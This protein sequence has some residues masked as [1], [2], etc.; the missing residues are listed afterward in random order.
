MTKMATDWETK[1]WG[2]TRCVRRL[3]NFS[4]YELEVEKGGFCSIH[5]HLNRSNEFLVLSGVVQVVWCFAWQ[6]HSR[7]LAV[8]SPS[9]TIRAGIPHQFQVMESGVMIEDYK[10]DLINARAEFSDGDIVRLTEGGRADTL[11]VAGDLIV[12][13]G[14]FGFPVYWNR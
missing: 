5:Y 2:R 1:V 13:V 7:L 14:A 10:P 11:M 3:A 6:T 8:N 12:S 4:R 9:L